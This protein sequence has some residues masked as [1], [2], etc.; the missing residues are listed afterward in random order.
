MRSGGYARFLEDVVQAMSPEM[1]RKSEIA[2]VGACGG[3]V[4]RKTSL[5]HADVV[6]GRGDALAEDGDD[7]D[8]RRACEAVQQA[9]ERDRTP[10]L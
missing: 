7:D 8:D 10:S 9:T 1:A 6:V 3:G 5:E 4:L 2:P